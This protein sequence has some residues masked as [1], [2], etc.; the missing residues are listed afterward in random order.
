M[1]PLQIRAAKGFNI[2]PEKIHIDQLKNFKGQRGLFIAVTSLSETPITTR[3]QIMN[4]IKKM[5]YY[6]VFQNNFGNFNNSKYFKKLA[7]QENSKT[8]IY[9]LSRN[10]GYLVK[11]N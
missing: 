6:I 5:D 1:L 4:E 8:H 3:K 2:F 11:I 10:A 9:P 7:L